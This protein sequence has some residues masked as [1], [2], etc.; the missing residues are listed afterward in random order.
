MKLSKQ[1]DVVAHDEGAWSV[2]WVPHTSSLLTGSVD[3]TVKR[4]DVGDAGASEVYKAEGQMLGVI[5][6]ACHG[7]GQFA[8]SSSLDSL[9]RVWDVND[10]NSSISVIEMA[11]TETWAIAFGPSESA[12]DL[13]VAGGTRNTVVLWRIAEGTTENVAELAAPVVSR[14]GGAEE[15]RGREGRPSVRCGVGTGG[16]S[17][18]EW[19]AL[20]HVNAAHGNL[21]C[22]AAPRYMLCTVTASAA[23]RYVAGATPNLHT[24]RRWLAVLDCADRPASRLPRPSLL[25]HRPQTRPPARSHRAR[26]PLTARRTSASSLC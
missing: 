24:T 9:I 23:A 21:K 5:S 12:V 3:E 14:R 15:R 18:P 25:Y 26:P 4:W 19:C 2:A 22:M 1:Y 7:T 13:A 17:G 10:H 6:V 8:A 16:T 20:L 11:P